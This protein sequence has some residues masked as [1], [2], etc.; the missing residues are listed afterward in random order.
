MKN[1]NKYRKEF[2]DLR[3][4]ILIEIANLIRKQPNWYLQIQDVLGK[5]IYQEIDS[6][7][8]EVIHSVTVKDFGDEGEKE[9]VW[10][11]V[12]G[13]DHYIDTEQLD[14]ELLINVLEAMIV[15]TEE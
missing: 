5:L 14:T 10:V 4:S 2:A 6:T 1:I 11:G 9:V 12:H 8:A 15:E 13:E 7:Q 3:D